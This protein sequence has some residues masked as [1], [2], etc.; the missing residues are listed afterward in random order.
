MTNEILEILGVNPTQDQLLRLKKVFGWVPNPVNVNLPDHLFVPD[1]VDTLD[2]FNW[3]AVPTPAAD[4]PI[5]QLRCPQNARIKLLE[6]SLYSTAPSPSD[7]LFKVNVNGNRVMSEHGQRTFG[8]VFNELRQ[9]PNGDLTKLIKTNVDL[10]PNDLLTV[11]VD[12][13][14]P[15]TH[16]I[17]IRFVGYV[18]FGNFR[19]SKVLG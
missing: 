12:K 11:A 15:G 5:F 16:D 17:G 18:D 19:D 14:V 6:Y 1:N 13:V 10:K 7:V 8:S 3:Q 4:T 9:M 2:L